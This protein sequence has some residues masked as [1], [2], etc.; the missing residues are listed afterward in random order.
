MLAKLL[1]NISEVILSNALGSSP[2][3]VYGTSTFTVLFQNVIGSYLFSDIISGSL[4]SHLTLNRANP[5]K[6][7]WEFVHT[8]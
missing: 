6:F 7:P 2:I 8:H 4:V 5:W 1:E 3:S